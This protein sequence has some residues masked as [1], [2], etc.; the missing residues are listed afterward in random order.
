MIAWLL[1]GFLEELVFRGVLLQRVSEFASECLAGWLSTAVAI[2]VA[3]V[4]LPNAPST[5]ETRRSRFLE[6]RIRQT[7]ALLVC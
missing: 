7:F 1:G 6:Y 5:R 4:G 3:A 2:G